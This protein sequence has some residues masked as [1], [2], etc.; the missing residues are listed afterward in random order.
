[1]KIKMADGHRYAVTI[2]TGAEAKH[3]WRIGPRAKKKCRRIRF[4]RRRQFD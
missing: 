4:F 1:M 2:A 3:A